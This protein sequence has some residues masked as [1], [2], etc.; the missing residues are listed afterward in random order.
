MWKIVLVGIGA[1]SLG[2]ATYMWVAP[3][4][5]YAMVPGVQATGPLNIHFARD[6]ALAYLASGA[7]LV[8]AGLRIDRSAALCGSAWLILHALFHIW[9]W[10]HRGAPADTV[11]LTNFAGVQLPAFIAL[12]AALNLRKERA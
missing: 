1:L 2:T 4:H 11:A 10:L 7:A 12:F 6:V 5:W 9:I 8:W 3:Q